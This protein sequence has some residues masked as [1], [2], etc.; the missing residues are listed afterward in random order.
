MDPLIQ[1]AES[2]GSI[3]TTQKVVPPTAEVVHKPDG[4]GHVGQGTRGDRSRGAQV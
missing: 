3:V 1:Q 4:L 2:A